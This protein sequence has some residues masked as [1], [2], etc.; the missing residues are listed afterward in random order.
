MDENGG[1][2]FSDLKKQAMGILQKEAELSEIVRLVGIESLSQ[3]DQFLLEIAR[4]IR[5][6]FLHQNAFL[7]ID[8]FTSLKKQFWMIKNILTVYDKGLG[9]IKQG[10]QASEVLTKEEK[11]KFAK[12]KMADEQT[13]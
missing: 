11:E 2:G 13:I 7:D 9:E 8:S 1:V 10:K 3:E 12:M 5:E 4:I 6:D